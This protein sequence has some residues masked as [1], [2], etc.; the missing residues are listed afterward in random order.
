MRTKKRQEEII[1]ALQEKLFTQDFRGAAGLATRSGLCDPERPEKLTL[2]T[3]SSF[4]GKRK[5][6]RARRPL[7]P[8]NLFFSPPTSTQS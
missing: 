7:L 2:P 3:D 1:T 4:L 6:M 8:P 5:E